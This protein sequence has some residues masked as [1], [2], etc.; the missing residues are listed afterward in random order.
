MTE[1]RRP[2]NSKP[3]TDTDVDSTADLNDLSGHN[4]L[5]AQLGGVLADDRARE[6]AR[7]AKSEQARKQN[8]HH[9]GDH[10]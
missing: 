6:A 1:T 7:W 8:A 5:S 9:R 3:T 10:K 4:M 2:S